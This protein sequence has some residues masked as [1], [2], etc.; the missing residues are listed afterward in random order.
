M[1]DP[2]ASERSATVVVVGAG[3]AGLSAA[4]H[5][6]RR[7]FVSALAE[8]D[9]VRTLRGA[10]RRGRGRAGPGRT[11][12]S[13]C[14]WRP[15]TGSSSC[16]LILSRRSTRRSPAAS[17]CRATSPRSSGTAR[18]RSLRPVAVIS[19]TRADGDPDGDLIVDT[20]HGRWRTRAVINATGTWDKPV[21]PHYPGQETFPGRQLHTRDYVSAAALAG[22]R[23]A[24]VGGGHLRGAAAGGDLA[25]RDDVLVHPPRARFPR[26]RV[27]AGGRGPGDDRAGHRRRRGGPAH[28]QRRL[29]HRAC[30]GPRT[31]SPPR[32]AGCWTG[33]R[34]SPRSSPTAYARPRVFHPVDVILWATGFK[35]AL[36]HLDPLGLR[37]DRGG[38]TLRGTQVADEPRVHSSA[39]ARRSRQ[40]GPTGPGGTRSPR[41]PATC[42]TPAGSPATTDDRQAS[43]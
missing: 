36:R 17:P 13:R 27:P 35:A 5:L 29:L 25:R 28:R 21:L 15:S 11:G 39:S 19:V 38:I 32:S 31:S 7:G 6:K 20:D 42:G 4:H 3:Q 8:P 33:G 40:S 2:V 22:R 24:V 23:V 10:G 16:R 14:G 1:G 37:N 43:A 34:C 30:P 18:S 41:S 12:G 26:R 9:A